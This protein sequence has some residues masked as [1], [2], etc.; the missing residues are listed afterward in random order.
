MRIRE[1]REQEMCADEEA[2]RSRCEAVNAYVGLM[3]KRK[4]KTRKKIK[5]RERVCGQDGE[6]EGCW[7]RPEVTHYDSA[8]FFWMSH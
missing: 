4:R 5:E 8:A 7:A 6:V 2:A 1:W 3:M